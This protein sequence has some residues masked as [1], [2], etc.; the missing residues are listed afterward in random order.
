MQKA[1]LFSFDP[2]Q[3]LLVHLIADAEYLYFVE[4]FQAETYGKRL[5]R[6]EIFMLNSESML[7]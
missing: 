5:V 3:I 2:E 4:N 6:Q 7:L 1:V